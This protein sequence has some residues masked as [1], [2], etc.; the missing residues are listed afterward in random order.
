MRPANVR[1]PSWYV[2]GAV[3]WAAGS[4]R[5]VDTEALDQS[6]SQAMMAA[7]G[8]AAGT[9]VYAQYV[10][11]DPAHAD[12]SGVGHTDALEFTIRD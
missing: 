9:T 11:W 5:G 4:V 8:L 12:G 1:C 10:Y 7:E 6:M 2:T 3:E